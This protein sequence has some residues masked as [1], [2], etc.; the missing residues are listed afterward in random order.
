MNVEACKKALALVAALTVLTSSAQAE[1]PDSQRNPTLVKL[2]MT[3][4]Q[5]EDLM[6]SSYQTCWRFQYQ[7]DQD[8][9]CFRDGKVSLY[10]HGLPFQFGMTQ[11]EVQRLI[12]VDD[13]GESYSAH[14]ASYRATF[15]DGRL[16]EFNQVKY[17]P[18]L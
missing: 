7:G 13:V 11:A 3:V 14:G 4:Q 16:V 12:K 18:W 10:R 17:P 9:V 15:V 5:V 2:G 1:T 6:G 8:G